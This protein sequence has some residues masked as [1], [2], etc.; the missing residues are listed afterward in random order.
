MAA[1]RKLVTFSAEQRESID[2]ARGQ[3]PFATFVRDAAVAAAV[4]GKPATATAPRQVSA[5][6]VTAPARPAEQPDATDRRSAARAAI[7]SLPRQLV[8]SQK[9]SP[10]DGGIVYDRSDAQD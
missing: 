3:T 10:A 9:P 5:P 4:N 2:K 7:A 8:P 1:T 6:R